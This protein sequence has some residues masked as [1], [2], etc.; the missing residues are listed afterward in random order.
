MPI[1]PSKR[2]R[3]YA[4]LYDHLGIR[5]RAARE[6]REMTQEALSKILGISR[7]SVV[8]IEQGR[9]RLDV[10]LFVK[11]ADATKTSYEDLLP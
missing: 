5:L 10:E 7:P 2:L 6:K 11:W 3:V 9:Q 4:S 8:N 1:V